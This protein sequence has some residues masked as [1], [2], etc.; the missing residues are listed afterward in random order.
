VCVCVC[1]CVITVA[2]FFSA[3]FLLS[4]PTFL[5]VPA[6]TPCQDVLN[7]LVRTEAISAEVRDVLLAAD[8]VARC[9]R[10]C[11]WH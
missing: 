4:S 7:Y 8:L 11:V 5:F 2:L 10:A 3:S 9:L 6:L 1:V